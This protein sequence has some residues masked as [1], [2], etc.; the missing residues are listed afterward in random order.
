LEVQNNVGADQWSNFLWNQQKN[1]EK[2]SNLEIIFYGFPR[3]KKYIWANSRK[4]GLVHS[5]YNIVYLIIMFFLF[6]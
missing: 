4:D 2:K 1:I 6:Q 5:R 3:E